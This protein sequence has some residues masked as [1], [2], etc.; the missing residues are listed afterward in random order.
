MF[1]RQHFFTL[2]KIA[3]G[4]KDEFKIY[5]NLFKVQILPMK[6]KKLLIY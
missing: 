5:E 4:N 3:N 6:M 2:K 1:W